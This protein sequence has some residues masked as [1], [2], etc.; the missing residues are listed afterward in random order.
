MNSEQFEISNIGY[1]ISKINYEIEGIKYA[2]I[3]SNKVATHET[4]QELSKI[5]TRLE[6]I[7]K[8]QE[9]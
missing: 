3:N 4:K 5:V 9:K 2:L 6:E 7:I 1:R 8:E